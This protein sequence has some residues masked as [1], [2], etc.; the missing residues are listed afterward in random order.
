M[1]TT[2]R[3]N[4]STTPARQPQ[5]PAVSSRI[6]LF[7][8][9]KAQRRSDSSNN[10]TRMMS[11][12]CGVFVSVMANSEESYGVDE[13]ELPISAEALRRK[14]ESRLLAIT[15]AASSDAGVVVSDDADD[16]GSKSH[17]PSASISTPV[18]EAQI[19]EITAAL[20]E[21]LENHDDDDDDDDDNEWILIDR[22]DF[23][24]LSAEEISSSSSSS[25]QQQQQ[26]LQQSD[27]HNNNNKK[28]YGARITVNFGVAQWTREFVFHQRKRGP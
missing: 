17:H 6:A 21:S 13:T 8:G 4:L 19:A 18:S 26:Q 25:S 11:R 23:D 9:M 20:E 16:D 1:P 22:E 14:V 15:Q 3:T 10:T 24:G 27:H 2:N 7:E 12:P 28:T 5:H